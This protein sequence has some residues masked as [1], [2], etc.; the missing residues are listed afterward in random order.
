MCDMTIKSFC[1]NRGSMIS[2]IISRVKK[3][4][5]FYIWHHKAFIILLFIKIWL[6]CSGERS[7]PWAMISVRKHQINRVFK[8]LRNRNVK[9]YYV[10]SI[11]FFNKNLNVK[12]LIGSKIKLSASQTPPALIRIVICIITFSVF[13]F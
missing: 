8:T 5:M 7:G 4:K 11:N 1:Y 9:L 6:C 2:K 3:S 13:W 12:V 10:I